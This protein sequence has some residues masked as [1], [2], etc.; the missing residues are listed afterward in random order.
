ML[1]RTDW[2]REL[3]RH[4]LFSALDAVQFQRI[5][6]ETRSMTFDAG[7]TLVS[8]GEPAEAFYIVASG[9]LKLS[10][11][12]PSGDEKVLDLLGP[13]RSFGEAMLFTDSPR[14]PVTAVALEDCVVVKVPAT[15]FR[16]LLRENRDACFGM[17]AHLSARLHAQVRE[18]EA[19]TLENAR[20]RLIR[21]LATRVETDSDGR[22]IARHAAR[23][24][25]ALD[26]VVTRQRHRRV[27]RSRF[28]HR[29]RGAAPGSLIWI[30]ATSAD[31][32]LA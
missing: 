22:S 4:H 10:L 29:Q 27:E 9:S 12:A 8:A 5:A 13:G 30:K 28:A 19:L 20:Q 1:M 6:Q 32:P 2:S 7:T 25:V 15:A 18:I 23:D 14:F 21:F 3:R 11:Y 26:Q 17:L 31:L 24:F 16:D